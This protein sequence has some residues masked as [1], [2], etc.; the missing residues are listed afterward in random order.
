[1]IIGVN[2]TGETVVNWRGVTIGLVLPEY[3]LPYYET[4]GVQLPDKGILHNIGTIGTLL[5]GA[6]D[7]LGV[8]LK[9][10]RGGGKL[11][12]KVPAEL[13]IFTPTGPQ[14]T[15]FLLSVVEI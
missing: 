5:P 3:F 4:R 15:A 10:D 11:L 7:T 8:D 6:W 13:R 1:M 14:S 12:R 2:N 9:V